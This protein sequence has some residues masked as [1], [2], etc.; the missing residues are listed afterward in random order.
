MRTLK[1]LWVYLRARSY[2]GITEHRSFSFIFTLFL[3]FW[4]HFTGN[5][6]F[7]YD[8]SSAGWGYAPSISYHEDSSFIQG[9]TSKNDSFQPL[10]PFS[11]QVCVT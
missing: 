4:Y 11:G 1:T 3:T 5:F 7:L 8:T 2:V 6:E 10:G 9:N